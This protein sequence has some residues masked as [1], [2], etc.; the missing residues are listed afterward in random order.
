MS[1]P[2][3]D[4]TGAAI[5]AA[6]QQVYQSQQDARWANRLAWYRYHEVR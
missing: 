6:M 3:R 5:A 1:T 2:T 4:L